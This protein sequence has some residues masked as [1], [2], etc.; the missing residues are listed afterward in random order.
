MAG[1]CQYAGCP[2][3]APGKYGRYCDAHRAVVRKKKPK[4]VPT[5][6]I[7]AW[8]REE[9]GGGH[10]G[11]KA[12]LVVAKRCG[13]PWWAITRRALALGVIRYRV[14]EAPWSEAEID[15][16]ERFAWMSPGAIQK[17]LSKGA[18][19]TRTPAA[20]VLK[21]KRMR[22]LANLDGYSATGLAELLGLDATTVARW[23]KLGWLKGQRRGSEAL[24]ELGRETWWIPHAAV[25]RFVLERPEHVDVR[26]VT[27]SLWFL[28]LVSGGALGLHDKGRAA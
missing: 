16:L 20:I 18:G 8:I 13:W 2:D 11:K 14:K 24:R 5:P 23:L 21:R 10:Y 17:R 25:R 9:W 27:D 1:T 15:I 22:L 6:Q 7:D 4:Y 28:D 19:V 3:V 26:K 12:A